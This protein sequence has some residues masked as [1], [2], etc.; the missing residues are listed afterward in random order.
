[1]LS[2]GVTDRNIPEFLGLI[3]QRID[4]L[5][6]MSKA[7]AHEKLY[8]EDFGKTAERHKAGM[9]LLAP[10]LPNVTEID[11]DEEVVD[12]NAKLQPLNISILKDIMNRKVQKMSM[13]PVFINNS[14]PL[15]NKSNDA[16]M[17]HMGKN[18]A[19]RS[20]ASMKSSDSNR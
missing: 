19:S 13:L 2:T 10:S 8:K 14:P 12:E 18:K 4:D 7:A 20:T 16:G 17:H 5:I 6:Q 1:M 9:P 3:E 11:E 15:S